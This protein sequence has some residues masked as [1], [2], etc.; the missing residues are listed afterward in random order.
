MGK[1]PIFQKAKKKNGE[2][3]FELR[4]CWEGASFVGERPEERHRER[5]RK[6]CFQNEK[7]RREVLPEGKVITNE[8]HRCREI[9]LA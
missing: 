6:R 8:G 3:H 5:G 7:T 9:L 2:R 4:G 1:R